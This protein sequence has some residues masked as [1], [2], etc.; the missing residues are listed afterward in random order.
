LSKHR[1][2]VTALLLFF[3]IATPMI[4]HAQGFQVPP[5]QAPAPAQAVYS[6]QQLDQMVAPVAL[7]PDPLLSQ[8][9]MASTYPLE[10][11]EAYR[12]QQSAG[13]SGLKGDQLAAALEQQPWDP[14]V[15]SVVAFPQVLK[16]MND[17]IQWTEQ[18][19]NAFLAQQPAVMDSVQHLRQQ[20][21]AA[22]NLNSTPQQVVS[23]DGGQIVIEPANPEVVYVPYYNPAVVY[24]PWP[25]AGYPPYY[26][27]DVYYGPAVFGF[28][29]GIVVIGELWGWDHWNWRHH[30][31]DIDEHRFSDLNRGRGPVGGGVW[32]HDPAHRGGVPYRDAATRAHFAATANSPEARRAVRGFAPSPAAA[33]RTENA[34]GTAQT[35]FREQQRTAS[36]AVSAQ[37]NIRAAERPSAA[38]EERQA[39]PAAHRFTAAPERSTSPVFESFS[40][41]ADVRAQSQRGA[42]SRAMM[43][44]SMPQRSEPQRAA[45][46]AAAPSGGHGGGFS[47]GG[48]AHGNEGGHNDKH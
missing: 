14:S 1:F 21:Q 2:N 5:E 32:E 19:G 41:G 42:A 47:G 12:W 36:P 31:I 20:A 11:V 39:A 10:V 7:Y 16:T 13:N 35:S 25:Y 48:A 9:L 29:V 22:H 33:P 43:P 37:P 38:G 6:Q 17:N 15:K 23:N 3:L 8:I 40:R 30:R 18:L 28:G 27:S 4:T 26:F 34:R 46:P 24:G 44:A 45:A